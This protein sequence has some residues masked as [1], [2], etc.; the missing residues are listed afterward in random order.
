MKRKK[1]A[2]KIV[3]TVAL[4]VVIAVIGVVAGIAYRNYS[5]EKKYVATVGG[6]KITVPEFRLFLTLVQ[7]EF[8]ANAGVDKNDEA[9][10][11]A[12]WKTK[13]EGEVAEE[14]AKNQALDRLKEFKI[15][16]IKAKESKVELEK[17]D[18]DKVKSEM[19]RTIEDEGKGNKSAANA[20]LKK[21]YGIT[22][23]NYESIY[24]NFMLANGKFAEKE[25]S[26]NPPD[27]KKLNDYFEENK[28][29]FGDAKVKMVKISITDPA[30]QAPLAEGELIDKKAMADD[31]L[32]KAQAGEDFAKLV[33]DY[34]EDITRNDDDGNV[35]IAKDDTSVDQKI[36]D[37][38]M[39]AKDGEIKRI[40]AAD[41]YYVLKFVNKITLEG[42]KE[43]VKADYLQND[44]NKK[45][46]GWMKEE[47]YN[48][49]KNKEVWDSIKIIK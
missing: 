39:T 40:D 13:V 35:I 42:I 41:G 32:K 33:T 27:D 23:A 37:W 10:W 30:T 44:M 1:S 25:A 5:F 29:R 28:N 9:A 22:L 16:L 21:K 7:N 6:E 45:L 24:K 20:A 47:K 3:I 14:K 34:S 38:V 31:V 15:L 12:F 8:E 4:L 36:R 43:T 19:D 26:K 48:V 2:F 46:E 17:E 18:L 49:V 11:K